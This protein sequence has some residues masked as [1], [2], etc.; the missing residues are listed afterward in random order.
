MGPGL[1]AETA[2]P[3]GEP[4]GACTI[5]LPDAPNCRLIFAVIHCKKIGG[6]SGRRARPAPAMFRSLG[7]FE[8][9][10]LSAIQFRTFGLSAAYF[11]LER[12]SHLLVARRSCAAARGPAGR[13]R[14]DI[15]EIAQG[16][17]G[18]TQSVA[19]EREFNVFSSESLHV[20]L[21]RTPKTNNMTCSCQGRG[22]GPSAQETTHSLSPS[23]KTHEV[24]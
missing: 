10:G 7:S 19:T 20:Y 8:T 5:F 15:A 16:F 18:P 17:H 13:I 22:Q 1:R 3:A 2:L 12:E 14:L 24:I 9:F 11:S 4:L 23:R 21:F 6:R